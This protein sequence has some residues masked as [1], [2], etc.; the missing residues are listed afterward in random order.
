MM[1]RDLSEEE[2]FI[3]ATAAQS[4]PAEYS[5]QRKYNAPYG[6]DYQFVKSLALLG[7]LKF[8]SAQRVP[9]GNDFVKTYR[10]TEAG[11]DAL[12]SSPKPEVE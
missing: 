5:V 8:E 10:I 3:L 6:D 11:R 9:D 2:T 12:R 1:T 7:F 4:E